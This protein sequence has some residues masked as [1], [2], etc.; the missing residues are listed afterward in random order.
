MQKIN[1]TKNGIKLLSESQL[2]VTLPS[3]TLLDEKLQE[4][5]KNAYE[6]KLSSEIN[7][8]FDHLKYD[9]II[10]ILGGRGAGKTS[11][12]KTLIHR[13]DDTSKFKLI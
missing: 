10:S 2:K 6:A 3:I 12:L 8:H 1:P 7:M 4:I 13:Y 5:R 9:N 11:V